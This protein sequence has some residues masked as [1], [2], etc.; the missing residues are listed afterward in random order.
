MSRD[1]AKAISWLGRRISRPRRDADS[2][3]APEAVPA[4]PELPASAPRKV[5]PHVLRVEELTVDFGGQRALDHVSL[6]TRPRSVLGVIGPNGAGK[7]TLVDVMTGFVQPA[8]GAV[9]VDDQAVTKLS[10]RR[11]AE[12]GISRSFQSLELFESLT[13]LENLQVATED[14]SWAA[15]A[16][17]LVRPR[18]LPLSSGAAVAIDD[19]ALGTDLRAVPSSLA[20]GRRRLVA[21]AR[22]VASEPSV[23]L[24]DEPASGLGETERRELAELIVYLARE[25]EM[26]ILLIEHDVEFVMQVCDEIVV[27]DHGSEI[28][29][30]KPDEVRTNPVVIEA[31]LGTGS[32]D[33]ATGF[34]EPKVV[35]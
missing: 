9:Y 11:L 21:V 31:Y 25:R 1:T 28:A 35:Q 26:S 17:D 4:W 14:R 20:Y 19:F 29:R 18:S 30:G 34:E 12:L 22:A 10:P 24:L 23:L 7:T 33:P 8:S 32:I 15:F 13:V 5:A 27:L 3:G 2:S 16:A 6:Q